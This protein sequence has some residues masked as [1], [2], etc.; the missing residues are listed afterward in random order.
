MA[1]VK[2]GLLN[3]FNAVVIFSSLETYD[4]GS[5]WF[6]LSNNIETRV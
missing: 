3:Q 5:H 6:I 2:S 4:Y 1:R